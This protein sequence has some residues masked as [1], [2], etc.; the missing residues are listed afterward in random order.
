MKTQRGRKHFNE[1][2]KRLRAAEPK[3]LKFGER[4]LLLRL[5]CAQ[6]QED[7]AKKINTSKSTINKYENSE[8][9]PSY[10]TIKLIS[11]KCKVSLDYLFGNSNSTSHEHND[12][13]TITEFSDECVDNLLHWIN[14]DSYNSFLF[15]NTLNE[16]MKDK[17]SFETLL[18][19]IYNYVK[20]YRYY[21]SDIEQFEENR[22]N[23]PI[24]RKL[25]EIND[26]DY[27]YE[28]RYLP[29][30]QIH[31]FWLI[32]CF[33]KMIDRIAESEVKLNG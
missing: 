5:D 22:K 9:E 32:D 28:S 13:K 14:F 4:L 23:N 26:G 30:A 7:F 19:E 11:E 24:T 10:D 25:M 29:E 8:S 6:N 2:V 27:V 3:D 20:N 16:L 12:L 18:I 21:K 1:K 31:K 17:E 15:S 33:T